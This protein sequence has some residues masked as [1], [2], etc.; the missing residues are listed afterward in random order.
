ML[1][2]P[3]NNGIV[4]WNV[5]FLYTYYDVLDKENT[6]ILQYSMMWPSIVIHESWLWKEANCQN[7]TLHLTPWYHFGSFDH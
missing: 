6:D 2:K 1:L 7:E 4:K 3:N 5:L